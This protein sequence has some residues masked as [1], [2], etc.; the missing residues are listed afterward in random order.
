MSYCSYV[1]F[2]VRTFYFYTTFSAQDSRDIGIMITDLLIPFNNKR[3]SA[4][5]KFYMLTHK[6]LK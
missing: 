5:S 2:F 3:G 6:I 4:P 1:R